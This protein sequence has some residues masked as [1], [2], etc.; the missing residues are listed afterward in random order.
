MME[1]GVSVALDIDSWRDGAMAISQDFH[2]FIVLG[3][4][5]RVP[6]LAYRAFTKMRYPRRRIYL[7]RRRRKLG[8]FW[9]VWSWRHVTH[10]AAGHVP[11]AQRSDLA[12]WS[13][14]LYIHIPAETM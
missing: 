1:Y 7:G 8:P 2:T 3:A 14:P 9:M 12:W 6:R 4:L 5:V 10:S 11:V 13:S